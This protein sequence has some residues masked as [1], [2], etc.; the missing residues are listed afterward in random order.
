MPS[1]LIKSRAQLALTA[2]PWIAVCLVWAGN[3]ARSRDDCPI[4]V[5]L[6]LPVAK[7]KNGQLTFAEVRFS[8]CARDTI[9]VFNPM[10]DRAV[11]PFDSAAVL[12]ILTAD[13]KWIADVWPN[14]GG[15]SRGV[16]PSHWVSIPPDA[17]FDTELRFRPGGSP[18]T[19]NEHMLVPGKYLLEMRIHSHIVSPRPSPLGQSQGH[20]GAMIYRQSLQDW[21]RTFPGSELCRSNRITL[22]VLPLTGD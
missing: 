1:R 20:G 18:G 19:V 21:E 5:T 15:T 3:E 17:F 9:E 12:A 13:G 22:E 2:V 6:R 4:R 8:N 10:L 11:V 7:V 14:D 16:H